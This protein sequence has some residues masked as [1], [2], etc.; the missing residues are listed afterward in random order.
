MP[1]RKAPLRR[2]APLRAQHR[3]RGNHDGVRAA[4]FGRDRG[5]RLQGSLWGTCFGVRQTAH[6]LWKASQ[7]GPYRVWNLVTL[8][9]LHND[10]VEDRPDDAHALGLVM[11]RGEDPASVWGRL[12][13]AGIVD[14]WW[15]GSPATSDPP[16]LVTTL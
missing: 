9:A 7:G 14:Y 3:G 10:M 13:L 16:I 5:C 1:R 4:V 6:H 11:R 8:C 12:Q 15:E 2:S